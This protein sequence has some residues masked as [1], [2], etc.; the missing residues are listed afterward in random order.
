MTTTTIN[1][2]DSHTGGEPTRVILSGWPELYGSTVAQKAKSF[3]MHTDQLRSAMVNEPRGS[4]IL[5][6]ALL[7]PPS[8]P[9]A[10]CG[11]I[12]FN[13]VGVLGMCGHGTI[14]LAVTLQHL[15]KLT[16]GVHTIETSVGDVTVELHDAHRVSVTNVPSFRF[17][18]DVSVQVP[19]LGKVHGDIAWGGNWFFLVNDHGQ[20]LS[21]KNAGTLTQVASDIRKALDAAG[22]KGDPLLNHGLIDHIELFG[23]ARHPENHSCNFVLCPGLAYDRSPCGTGTSAKVACLVADGKLQPGQ[24][25][26]QESLTGSVFEATYMAEG[27]RIQP[28]IA[29]TAF[30]TAR[31]E[32]ILDPADPLRYG[33]STVQ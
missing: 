24:V 7:L 8:K 33:F 19:G 22:L 11:V 14:G 2:V 6:G 25:W 32:L 27:D 20:E 21:L 4:D 12:F 31:G 5:V 10:A 26:R 3:A 29:G 15:G 18:K 9:T 16:L 30:V 13:N 28:T 17:A 23:P 1:F